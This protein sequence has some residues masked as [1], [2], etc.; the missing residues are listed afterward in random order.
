MNFVFQIYNN[1]TSAK[2]LLQK[3][4]RTFQSKDIQWSNVYWVF[5]NN[6]IM[7]SGFLSIVSLSW[8]F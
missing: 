3:H 1:K 8:I 6:E 4:P 5:L 2:K 7:K